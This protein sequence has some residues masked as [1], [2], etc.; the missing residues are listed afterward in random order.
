[1]TLGRISQTIPAHHHLLGD[2]GVSSAAIEIVVA[3]DTDDPYSVQFH[4]RSASVRWFVS[5]DLVISGLEAASGEGDVRVSTHGTVGGDTTIL[6][7]NNHQDPPADFTLDAYELMTFLQL[8]EQMVPL[9]AETRRVQRQIER[10]D[11][12]RLAAGGAEA[13]G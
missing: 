3:Y 2:D 7:L 9:G 12:T 13:G 5:R 1:M 8:T 4:F 10:L 6:T 11:W